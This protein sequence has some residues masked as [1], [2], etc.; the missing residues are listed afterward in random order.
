MALRPIPYM[1]SLK[2]RRGN[3]EHHQPTKKSV[4]RGGY[5]KPASPCLAV[6]HLAYNPSPWHDTK[7]G[8][9]LAW[10]KFV[11]GA[12]YTASKRAHAVLAAL[13]ARPGKC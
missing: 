5:L 8:T 11:P 7:T 13:H 2:S 1:I 10:V 6:I 4:R 12:V 9:G 3:R